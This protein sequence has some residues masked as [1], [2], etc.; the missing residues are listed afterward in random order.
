MRRGLI[1][2]LALALILPAGSVRGAESGGRWVQ[3]D[4]DFVA[5]LEPGEELPVIANAIGDGYN[6]FRAADALD[7]SYVIRLQDSTG[8]ETFRPHAEEAARDLRNLTG[9][10]V[11]VAPGTVPPG[12]IPGTGEVHVI[13]TANFPP[14]CAGAAGCGGV[15][16]RIQSQLS[17]VWYNESGHVWIRPDMVG[18][19]DHT[20]QHLMSHEVGHAFGLAHFD[21]AYFGELQVM[22]S[23]NFTARSFRDGDANGI[24]HQTYNAR[25]DFLGLGNGSRDYPFTG[26]ATGRYELGGS[27]EPF[28]GDFD[29]DGRDDVFL[30]A[31]GAGSDA[32][33]WANADATF[34]QTISVDGIDGN[35][36]PVVADFDR[37]GADDIF[38]HTNE[39]DWD[40]VWWGGPGRRSSGW[41]ANDVSS[42]GLQGAYRPFAGDFDRDGYGDLFL[43]GPGGENDEIRWGPLLSTESITETTLKS[44]PEPIPSL[45]VAPRKTTYDVGGSYEPVAGDFDGDGYD[46]IYWYN[47]SGTDDTF[48]WSRSGVRRNGFTSSSAPNSGTYRVVRGDYDGDGRDD[49]M[50]TDPEKDDGESILW[51][52]F[53]RALSG[54]ELTTTRGIPFTIFAGDYDGDGDSDIWGYRPGI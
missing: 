43:Y 8:I 16:S 51:G 5:W 34:S 36:Q 12:S 45:L 32:V 11:T 39:G 48:W 20:R 27:Y 13:V 18:E 46:D 54:Q 4:G 42:L 25:A 35:Y 24:R 52:T 30:Y 26:D 21:Q 22:H 37:N 40:H 10:S 9:L 28:T 49:L 6:L 15:R 53:T 2:V 23:S 41:S 33:L 3:I 50:M 38:W 47:R 44:L 29:G 19:T 7:T 14:G 1:A 31:P 17:G